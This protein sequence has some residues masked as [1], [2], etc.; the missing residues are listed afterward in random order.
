MKKDELRRSVGK[1]FRIQPAMQLY[2]DAGA[3]RAPLDEAWILQKADAGEFTLRNPA[4]EL[5][6]TLGMDSYVGFQE[7]PGTRLGTVGVLVLKVQI[8][9]FEDALHF[10]VV[11]APGKS[12]SDFTPPRRRRT[13]YDA[14]SARLAADELEERQRE[15]SRSGV[16]HMQNALAQLPAAFAELQA[17]FAARGK[18]PEMQ[19]VAY[20]GGHLLVACG[21]HVTIA[22]KWGHSLDNTELVL[23]QWA[24]CPQLPGLSSYHYDARPSGKTT[25]RYGLAEGDKHGWI[26][27]IAN[28]ALST[29][30]VLE[31]LIME[32][33]DRP[34]GA[35]PRF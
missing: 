14:V 11:H 16:P 32:L 35:R 24:G 29:R 6:I 5:D 26:G 33:H 10:Q 1:L 4:E 31:I 34:M 27:Q 23:Q 8:Y 9:L 21:W 3:L 15:F 13:V 30:R 12:L 20:N 7:D 25:Y 18:N 28:L 17:D 2:N 19:L 22:V